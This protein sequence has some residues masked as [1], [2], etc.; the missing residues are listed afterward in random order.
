MNDIKLN[1]ANIDE[2]ADA[3]T[4]AAGELHI[5]VDDCERVVQAAQAELRGE[6][7]NA[8]ADFYLQ[9]STLDGDMASE[10]RAAAA[11]LHEMHGLLRDADVRAGHMMGT[12]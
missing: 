4:Q 3:L 1:H 6:L 8:A 12:R 9:L 11:I 5:A 7:K 2:A 10:L